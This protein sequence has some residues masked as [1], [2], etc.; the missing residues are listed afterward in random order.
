MDLILFAIYLFLAVF[1]AGNMTTLQIQHYGIYPF[2]GKDNFKNYMKA[3]NKSAALPSVLPTM[4]LLVVSFVLLFIRPMFMSGTEV[5]LS[6]S[7][8][9]IALISTF[10]WQRKIQGEMAI[11]GYDESKIDLLLSTNW[12]RVIAFLTQAIMAVSIIIIALKEKLPIN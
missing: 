1:N 9:I 7:L 11:T 5:I 3:N 12:I 10:T 2:V 4:L 8:N 6:I